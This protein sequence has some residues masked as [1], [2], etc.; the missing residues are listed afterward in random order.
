[1]GGCSNTTF[2]QEGYMGN[3]LWQINVTAPTFTC[4]YQDLF[5]N[6]TCNGV[7]VNDTEEDAIYYG[8][9]AGVEGC[10]CT[11]PND[12]ASDKIID[13]ACICNVTEP[14]WCKNL[15]FNNSGTAT[16]FTVKDTLIFK[17]IYNQS[18]IFKG[19]INGSGRVY[20][21]SSIP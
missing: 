17:N 2:Q 19:F 9:C 14:S 8:A 15:Y 18:S 6:A 13:L 16:N 1:V 7:L 20:Q 3:G 21:N 5:V 10:N 11:F 4:D 12:W